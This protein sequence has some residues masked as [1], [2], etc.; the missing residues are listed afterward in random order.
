MQLWNTDRDH[1]QVQILLDAL[2]QLVQCAVNRV[3]AQP[4][5]VNVPGTDRSFN[6]GVGRCIGSQEVRLSRCGSVGYPRGRRSA[7]G[8]SAKTMDW[9]NAQS[10]YRRTLRPE[11]VTGAATGS[12][13]GLPAEMG[14]YGHRVTSLA[15]VRRTRRTRHCPAEGLVHMHPP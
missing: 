8:R 5:A 11:A 6:V 2:P 15:P 12:A 14:V 1:A 4:G 10:R 13:H 7:M 3:A 9:R